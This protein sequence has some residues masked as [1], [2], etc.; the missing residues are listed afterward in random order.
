ML[1]SL[2]LVLLLCLGASPLLGASS[3]R[4]S[5]PLPHGNNVVD[6][7]SR[8]GLVVQVAELGQLYTSPD[9]RNWTPR[10]TH[11]RSALQAVT[12]LNDRLVATG[13]NGTVV[14]S[15]DGATFLTTNLNTTDWLV[16]VAASPTLAVAVGDNAAVY[17]SLN[18]AAW[19]RQAAPP[20]VSSYWLLSV[21]YGAGTFVAVGEHGYIATSANGTNWTYRAAPAVSPAFTDN[22]MRVAWVKSSAVGSF[23]VTNGFWAVADTGRALYSLNG[24]LSWNLVTNLNCTNVLYAVAGSETNRLL[25]GDGEVRTSLSEGRLVSWPQQ[26]GPLPPAAPAW[27]YYS[28]LWDTDSGSYWLAGDAGML[29]QGTPTN[30]LYRWQTPFTPLRDWLWDVTVAAGLY[31]AVGDHARITTSDDGVQ[32]SVEAVPTTNSVSSSNTVFFGVG[33][34]TN[35]LLA[36]GSRGSLALSPN[37]LLPV[38][39]TNA[40][41]GLFTNLV[42]TMGLA[43]Y[44]MLP[45]T[46]NDLNAVAVLS[47]RYYV[48]GGNGTLLSSANGT[49]WTTLSSPVTTYLSSLETWTNGLVAVGDAGTILT[50]PN[51]ST[52]TKRNYS[53]TNWL[54]RVRCLK[55]T[56]VAV[57]ENGMILV[58]SNALNWAAISSGVNTWLTDLEAVGDRFYVL[59]SLGTVLTSTNL[60][61]WT[62]FGANTLKSLYGAATQ[63][64]QLLAVGIEGVIIRNALIPDLNPVNF[65]K[66]A[67]SGQVNLFL[68]EGAPDQRFRLDAST[69]LTTWTTNGPV[70]EITDDSGT[71]LFLQDTGPS[72]PPRGSYRTTI[73]P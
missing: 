19:K 23:V 21:A 39:T 25:A 12:F 57:G 11:T 40:N 3:W 9:F 44:P 69:N 46:T 49:N 55:A 17:T 63:N 34:D 2:R 68:V 7:A 26:A 60:T 56:L 54:Y 13:E 24:G 64:G 73:V 15:D 48:A 33:G 4:W 29:V 37:R 35:L 1:L 65:L 22:L 62:V 16:G 27:T 36:V 59:G 38:V 41:G 71:L 51:G 18:G 8:N 5:N 61:N 31:V 10:D 70:L 66:Y 42:S 67:R 14:Y 30:A 6:M 47:N 20:N 50:S 53:T 32:W 52:W 58:S 72:A 43:W 45:P 28:A